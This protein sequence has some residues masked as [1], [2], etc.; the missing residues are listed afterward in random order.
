M[1]RELGGA[2]A[3]LVSENQRDWSTHLPAVKL[4]LNTAL[5][6]STG[7]MPY[8]VVFK[9]IP[10]TMTD[11]LADVVLPTPHTGT[12]RDQLKLL[13]VGEAQASRIY[14]KVSTTTQQLSC[15]TAGASVHERTYCLPRVFIR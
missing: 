14:E 12:T 7:E 1:N 2:L 15:R 6:D 10:R 3:K 5:H 4:S 13:D 9:D 8:R 11:V